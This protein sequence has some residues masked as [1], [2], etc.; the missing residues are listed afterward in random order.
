MGVSRLSESTNCM[1]VV[2]QQVMYYSRTYT[3]VPPKSDKTHPI[4]KS[5]FS[6]FY[7]GFNSV[8]CYEWEDLC[9]LLNVDAATIK[10]L[11]SPTYYGSDVERKTF[12]LQEFF[13]T[14][15]A[16]WEH[17]MH[18]IASD[19]LNKVV[20]AKEIGFEHDINYYA[21]M[22]IEK[23]MYTLPQGH[24]KI[25]KF[26]DL[27]YAL[28]RVDSDDWEVICELFNVDEPTLAALKQIKYVLMSSLEKF[29]FCLVDYLVYGVATWEHVMQ[30]VASSPLDQIV[31]A[32]DIGDKYG[33]NYH[34]V[35]GLEKP[36]RSISPNDHKIKK[37]NDLVR[38]MRTLDLDYWLELCQILKVDQGVIDDLKTFKRWRGDQVKWD[39]CVREYFDSG[40]ATWEEVVHIIASDPF[41]KIIKAKAIAR[42]HGI[43]YQ[44]VMSRDEL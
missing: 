42:E 21:V 31:T 36:A 32:K 39:R 33:I 6:D 43:S 44:T 41:E 38:A 9:R 19:P 27:K 15:Q 12:C 23:P 13:D 37:F 29:T 26:S 20:G 5:K 22:G 25:K 2:V 24:H 7:Y 10:D 3:A 28:N 8:S 30:V 40:G 34:A 4:K 11:K 1:I 14:G 17:V 16:T 35:M 18:T